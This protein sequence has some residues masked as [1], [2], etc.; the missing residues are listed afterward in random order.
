M[1]EWYKTNFCNRRDWILDNL[2][3]LA[4]EAEEVL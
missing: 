3:Y 1:K 4:L 2:E